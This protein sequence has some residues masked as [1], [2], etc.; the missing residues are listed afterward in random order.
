VFRVTTAGTSSAT[1]PSWPTAN[2]ATVTNGTAVFTNVTGQSA[3]GWTAAAQ[4]LFSMS[5]RVL[6]GDR[7]FLAHDHSETMTSLS[8]WQFNNAVDAFGLVQ[9][10]SVNRAGSVPPVAADLQ[11]GAALAQ[12]SGAMGLEAVCN[13]Y[14]QGINFTSLSFN[15]SA[16]FGTKAHYFKN[17]AF[18]FASGSGP[19]QKLGPYGNSCRMTFD[20]TSVQFNDVSQTIAPVSTGNCEIVWINTAVPLVGSVIPDAMFGA[21]GVAAELVTCR[22]VDF[23]RC[24]TGLVR[25]LGPGGM[26]KAL[27]DSCRVAP[28]MPR[29]YT[30]AVTNS[31]SHDEAEY[32]NCFDGTNV[33]NERYTAAGMILDDRSVYL[34]GSAQD[35][36]GP[37]SLRLAN[38]VRADRSVLTLDNFWMDLRNSDVG[39]A[40]T[41]VMEIIS[42]ATLNDDDIS[43]LLEYLGTSGSTLASF[44]SSLPPVLAA[45][46]ALP[47]SSATWT[48][49]SSTKWNLGDINAATL[50]NS[51]LTV[52]AITNQAGVRASVGASSGKYYFEFP[53]ITSTTAVD[54][55]GLAT[56]AVALNMN[57]A[58]S[59]V[60][61]IDGLGVCRV[62]SGL[63]LGGGSIGGTLINLAV[64]VDFDAA[65]AWFKIAA[66]NWNGSGTANPATGVGGVNISSLAFPL[67]PF[68]RLAGIPETVTANFGASAFGGIVPSGFNS[69]WPGLAPVKQKLQVSF[70]PQR[71]GRV[72]GLVKLGKASTTCWVDPKITIT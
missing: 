46:A 16:S 4:N 67:F 8:S 41:A 42:S 25:N 70:T 39:V 45:G 48:G 63:P 65:L 62:N 59:P 18:V 6:A 9:I 32:I 54:G 38:S 64:A 71:A 61:C 5:A 20:N 58:T 7:A 30:P 24:T 37:Y 21:S 56:A 66:G 36:T 11:V 49:P 68:A 44:V 57:V 51:D 34:G 28:G 35:D 23:N 47:I 40:K 17:C 52:T 15:I 26:T 13:L 14:W 69:G 43:L 10:L 60:A 12:L 2:N 72:R 22:G 50:S 29:F 31:H 1:E 53:S 3:Y 55:F 27:F 19:T 33:F